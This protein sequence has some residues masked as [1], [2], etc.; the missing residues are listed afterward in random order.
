MTIAGDGPERELLE[1]Q[2]SDSGLQDV[3]RFTGARSRG[4]LRDLIRS[5]DA[6]VSPS[7]G[8]TCGLVAAEAMACGKP[9]IGTRGGGPEYVVTPGTGVLVQPRDSVGLADAMEAYIDGHRPKD[10][11][12]IRASVERRFGQEEFLRRWAE[13]YATV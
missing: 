3:C 9:V 7:L 2:M 13:V 11:A 12:A 4:E 5:A 1:R 10:A 6:L 8:E